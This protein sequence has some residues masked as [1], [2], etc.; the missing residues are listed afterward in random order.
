MLCKFIVTSCLV[1]LTNAEL[2]Y[3]IYKVEDY[4]FD[5]DGGDRQWTRTEVAVLKC[6]K[7]F[8]VH[9]ACSKFCPEQGEDRK[10]LLFSFFE[11]F[12]FMF[13]TL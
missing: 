9:F 4:F 6:I 11:G 5:I 10:K 2:E 3:I 12:L 13:C 7:Q 8:R 1:R